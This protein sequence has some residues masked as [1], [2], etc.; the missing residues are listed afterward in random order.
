MNIKIEDRRW[1]GG[2]RFAHPFSAHPEFSASPWRKKKGSRPIPKVGLLFRGVVLSQGQT[3]TCTYFFR[4]FSSRRKT[5]FLCRFFLYR[6]EGM[7][8]P[9]V[10]VLNRSVRKWGS[11]TDV[12]QNKGGVDYFPS[13]LLPT[14]H[15][16]CTDTLCRS[17]EKQLRYCFLWT[18]WP[19]EP[20]FLFYARNRITFLKP[21]LPDAEDC[22]PYGF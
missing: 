16:L 13:F 3:P 14:L 4:K 20:Y 19:H 12:G 7:C 15:Q 2:P 10:K 5:T 9:R 18:R 8:G 6:R 1:R 17:A 22:L 11:G 21:N